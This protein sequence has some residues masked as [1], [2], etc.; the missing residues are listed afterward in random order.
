MIGFP[1]PL[2]SA[3]RKQRIPGSRSAVWR[4]F[5]RHNVTVKK[6]SLRATEQDRE[7]VAK[8]RRRWMRKQGLFDPAHLVCYPM[9]PQPAPI[10]SD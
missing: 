10:W 5:E 6:K 3:M 4:F 2:A 1:S 8:A 9:R 7:D